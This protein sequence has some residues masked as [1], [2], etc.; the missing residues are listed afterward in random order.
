[1]PQEDW[2][3]APEPLAST[4]V[5]SPNT[6]TVA[7][8]AI[9]QPSNDTGDVVIDAPAQDSAPDNATSEQ[10]AADAPIADAVPPIEGTQ[11][12]PIPWGKDPRFQADNAAYKSGKEL[13]S[14]IAK[15]GSVEN[16]RKVLEA[17]AP[18]V[19]TAGGVDPL[20]TRFAEQERVAKEKQEQES[21]QQFRTALDR[22]TAEQ[23]AQQVNGVLAAQGITTEYDPEGHRTAFDQLYTNAYQAQSLVVKM[24]HDQRL[25]AMQKAAVDYPE[26]DPEVV[27]EIAYN[28][29][30]TP[31]AVTLYAKQSAAWNK[32]YAAPKDAEIARLTAENARLSGAQAANQT[33]AKDDAQIAL[34]AEMAKQKETIPP[35]GVTAPDISATEDH[36]AIEKAPWSDF[37]PSLKRRV[38]GS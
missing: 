7:E 24:T 29:A 8:T 16:V 10:Q 38:F 3:M 17:I 22:Q 31:E 9:S 14:L 4:S 32:Q 19:D 37:M 5:N 30:M 20:F 27:K 21:D 18:E 11:D 26:A 6:E 25:A 2:V 12:E 34:A 13:E 36:E 35:E 15:Y 33:K 1:M 23:V 28:P